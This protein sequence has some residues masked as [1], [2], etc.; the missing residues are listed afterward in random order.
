MKMLPNKPKKII[1]TKPP[2]KAGLPPNRTIFGQAFLALIIFLFLVSLYSLI[3]DTSKAVEEISLSTLAQEISLGN[4]SAITITG[5]KL[6]ITLLDGV[7]K[8]SKKEVG[9]ALST[10]LKNYDVSPE[11]L[12][13]VDIE[14]KNDQ[15]FM[16]WFA[17]LAPILLPIAFIVFFL[18]FLSRQVKGAG[19]Q[20]FSFG[21]SK[22]RLT[23]PDDK[24]QKVTFKDVAG[25]KEAKE[26][27]REIV[28]FLKNPKK[29]LD[30]GA[31]MRRNVR[32]GWSF[33]CARPL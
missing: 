18:W 19:M 9:T 26:E 13:E 22:A 16:Y 29:F 23:T 33:S 6:E 4:V 2:R 25:C 21:Q 28:D 5:D 3:S 1:I 8:I 27:L 17:S 31:P 11:A 30:I 24:N 20:A 32:G 7:E 10:T 14:V 12:S 15:G